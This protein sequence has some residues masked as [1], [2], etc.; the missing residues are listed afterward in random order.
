MPPKYSIDDSDSDFAPEKS[1]IPSDAALEQGLRDSV[2]AI[3]ASG[4]LEDLTV[5]RV[6]VA[7]EKK[8]GLKEGFFKRTPEWKAHSD[9]II[10][11]EVVRQTSFLTVGAICRGNY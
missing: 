7:V 5:R 11:D 6:R 1:S 10:K 9:Q 3:F 8:L 2:V 4:K